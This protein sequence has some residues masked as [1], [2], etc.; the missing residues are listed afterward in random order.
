MWGTTIYLATCPLETRFGV[1]TA[2]VFQDV[3]DKHYVIAMTFGEV[4]GAE[5]L[6]T[7]LHSSCLTSE[8]LGGC[9]CDCAQ[10][11]EGAFRT[12]AE[13]GRGIL[14]YLMQEGRGVGF[15]G[16]ARDRMLVQASQ[17][18]VSTFEAYEAFG[19][20]HD[21]RNYANISHICH[22][23]GI[24]ASF[25]VLT[26]NPEKVR[27]IREAGFSISG[28]EPLEFE[29]GPFNIAYLSSKANC[30]HVLKRPSASRVVRAD[31][32]HPVKLFK[33]HVL[34][35]AQRFIYGASYFLPM[36][37]VGGEVVLDETRFGEIFAGRDLGTLVADKKSGVLAHE[38]IRGGRHLVGIDAGALSELARREPESPLGALLTAPYLFQAHAYYDIVK[39]Q[40][41]VV[42]TYGEPR[43]E[44]APVVRVH[45]ESLFNRFPLR[46]RENRDY[47]QESVRHI[48]RYGAGA[49]ILLHD[50]GRGAGFGAYAAGFMLENSGGADGMREAFEKLGVDYDSRD[51]DAAM[52]LLKHHI[53]NE[54][55]QMVMK[56]PD[57]LVRDPEYAANLHRRKIDV[58]RWIFLNGASE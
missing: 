42:L 46:V 5:V 28:T 6:H 17:D 41:V 15:F 14:F 9:D 45:S 49:L 16:K 18:E 20:R 47:F 32:E 3:V 58:A 30:G 1:F 39:S 52:L 7:R 36:R 10:Q 53:P 23:L 31:V 22:L 33:P 19:L 43:A 51:H 37:P 29:P 4:R 54:R 44:D 8:T 25:I 12:I 56:S 57:S 26:N 27:A 24:E 2:H 21:H 11:L 34:P 13:R 40:D 35:G 55:I 48:V 38:V 50:D